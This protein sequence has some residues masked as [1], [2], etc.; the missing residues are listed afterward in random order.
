MPNKKANTGEQYRVDIPVTID[1][2]E[3][4]K[5][6]KVERTR[7]MMEKYLDE[8]IAL[9][10][11]VVHAKGLFRL[12]SVGAKSDDWVEIEGVKFHS[13]VLSKSLANIETVVPYLFTSGKELDELPVPPGDRLRLYC[14]DLIKMQVTFQGMAYLM[15]YLK[16][17]FGYPEVTHLHPGEFADLGIDAQ[18]PLFSLFHDTEEAIGLKLTPNKTLSPIKSG[19]GFLFYNGTS[20]ISCELCLQAQCPGRHAAYNPKLAA[21]F[22]IGVKK[23]ESGNV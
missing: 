18:V 2:A 1:R 12:A 19:S 6:F 9:A 17:K 15:N 8:M 7:P 14:L 22:G 23:K 11:P 20:F 4:V 3:L 16:D 21:K 5:S 10:R 13:K